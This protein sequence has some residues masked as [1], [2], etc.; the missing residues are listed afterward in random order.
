MLLYRGN[1]KTK[2]VIVDGYCRVWFI[3]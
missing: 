2:T 3:E 1:G